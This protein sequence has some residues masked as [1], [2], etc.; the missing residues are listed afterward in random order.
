[1]IMMKIK[2]I[3]QHLLTVQNLGLYDR[4]TRVVLA[5][6]MIGVPAFDLVYRDSILGWHAYLILLSIYPALTAILGW[7]PFY[8]L[9]KIR[10]CAIAQ[11]GTF[12]YQVSDA[13][14]HHPLVDKEYE[15]D[16]S[17]SSDPHKDTVLVGAKTLKS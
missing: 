11:A 1:M 9:F 15:F 3:K 6:L 2:S 16:H 13:L 5:A 14:G 8:S 17:L 4:L 10:S 12:P 7:D